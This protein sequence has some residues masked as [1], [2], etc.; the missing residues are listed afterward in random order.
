[1]SHLQGL[2][3]AMAV[4]RKGLQGPACRGGFVGAAL[5]SAALA[6]ARTAAEHLN[7]EH[8]RLPPHHRVRT[9]QHELL[10]VGADGVAAAAGGGHLH[11][12]GVEA[13]EEWW[14]ERVSGRP[15]QGAPPGPSERWVPGFQPGPSGRG[16]L[17]FLSSPAPS[18]CG[19]DRCL[20]V[21]QGDLTR[22]QHAA[23][24]GALL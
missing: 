7:C 8:Q 19:A 12:V 10:L 6:A 14:R 5:V 17:P 9:G 16:W 2:W 20:C 3:E 23:G 4:P 11:G 22:W 18:R 1:M 15:P 13:A 24:L 21:G